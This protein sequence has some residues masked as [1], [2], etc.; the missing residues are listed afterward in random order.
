MKRQI[1]IVAADFEYELNQN[2]ANM[3]C[4]IEQTADIKGEILC[5]EEELKA[6]KLRATLLTHRIEVNKSNAVQLRERVQQ[7]ETHQ[8]ECVEDGDNIYSQMR[9]EM[10][11]QTA[12]ETDLF[13]QST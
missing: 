6:E 2:Y 8:N 1:P 10:N 13:N 5:L 12:T 4:L 3:D 11:N 9:E 7:L